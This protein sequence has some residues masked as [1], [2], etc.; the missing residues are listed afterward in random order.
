M[1]HFLKS[2][3]FATA[4][5]VITIL[6][7]CLAEQLRNR[8]DKTP[9]YDAEYI[10]SFPPEIDSN[11]R[12]RALLT[13]QRRMVIS[14][15][16]Y[17]LSKG[18]AGQIKIIASN[19]PD[20]GSIEKLITNP[21]HLS[22]HELYSILDLEKAL[23]H[24]DSLLA[25]PYHNTPPSSLPPSDT[26]NLP[27]P[28]LTD[29]SVPNEHP[30]FSAVQF[31]H[32]MAD[33]IL[34]APLGYVLPGNS[35]KVNQML[36]ADSIRQLFPGN[37]AFVY[38][39]QY[40]FPSAILYAIRTLP[41][42]SKKL[43]DERHITALYISRTRDNG[44]FTS[45]EI[46]ASFNTEGAALWEKLTEKNVH[47]AIAIVLDNEILSAPTVLEPITGGK[48]TINGPELARAKFLE[49]IIT[50]GR[51]YD[52]PTVTSRKITRASSLFL[53]V[54]NVSALWLS[55]LAVFILVF[56]TYFIFL[57]PKKN[58]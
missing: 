8:K 57:R 44:E 49:G 31:A 41:D 51:L 24:A 33:G 46:T 53:N 19:M 13:I 12:A 3:L 34:P 20:S 16:D 42:S 11:S 29:A 18:E 39:T 47:R 7:V 48:L 9:R 2:L 58:T 4:A 6:I 35:Q 30:L 45:A 1:S 32:P 37:L 5:G 55:A 27:V 52:P 28:E 56:T 22:F 40:D 14:D 10:I 38:E 26:V 21:G 43:L 50:G 25:Q 15:Y 17:K 36:A 23:K 54:R